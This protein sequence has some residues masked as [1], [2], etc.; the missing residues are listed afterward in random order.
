M[1]G[2]RK[3]PTPVPPAPV[4]QHPKAHPVTARPEHEVQQ[5]AK[6]CALLD[7]EPAELLLAQIHVFM[8]K[9]GIPF[10]QYA[11]VDVW[12]RSKCPYGKVWVWRPLRPKDATKDWEIVGDN[13]GPVIWRKN[14]TVLGHGSYA[15]NEIGRFPYSRLVPFSVLQNVAK[16][17]TA[18]PDKLLFF[19]SDYQA[20]VPDPFIALNTKCTGGNMLIFDA[21]DEPGFGK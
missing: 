13:R 15:Y 12:L 5:Y 4:L 14:I 1:F 6:Q 16:L 3:E 20:A 8:E 21:W 2:K 19:V 7:F 10:Y 17:E 9:N 18:F 11:E